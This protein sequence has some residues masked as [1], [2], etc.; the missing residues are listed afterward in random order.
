M[1]IN[2]RFSLKY[3]YSLSEKEFSNG[4]L[5]CSYEAYGEYML[6]PA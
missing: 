3:D 6:G 5:S 1:I 2:I 4:L